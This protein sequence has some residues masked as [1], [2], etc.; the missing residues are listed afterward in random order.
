MSGGR[1]LGGLEQSIRAQ[2]GWEGSLHKVLADTEYQSPSRMKMT[3]TLDIIHAGKR[4]P[5][6]MR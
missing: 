5:G 4:G 2:V 3:F 6:E 1:G